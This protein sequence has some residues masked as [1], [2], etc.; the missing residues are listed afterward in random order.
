[1]PEPLSV[2]IGS[3]VV[4]KSLHWRL[5]RRTQS[6]VQLHG[7]LQACGGLQHLRT[8]VDSIVDELDLREEAV[9]TSGVTSLL[10]N[11]V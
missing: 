5:E 3:W 9:P 6:S 11:G 1:M 10:Q 8:D 4:V 2:Q 7:V